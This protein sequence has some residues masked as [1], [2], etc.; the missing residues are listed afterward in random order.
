MT[1]YI[2][3]EDRFVVYDH[4]EE[5]VKAY[6]GDQLQ[7]DIVEIATGHPPGNFVLSG[8]DTMPGTL[9]SPKVFSESGQID[10][11]GHHLY[12]R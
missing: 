2:K 10:L 9:T 6:T 3:P 8:G 12:K 11:S 5:D 1:T 4:V 7:Q